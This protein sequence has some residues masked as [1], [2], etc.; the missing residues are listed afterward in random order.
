MEP[1]K[2][3]CNKNVIHLSRNHVPGYFVPVAVP[4]L[5]VPYMFGRRRQV[6]PDPCAVGTA[7]SSGT[8]STEHLLAIIG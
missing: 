6:P 5:K 2:G 8:D 4:Y 7:D 1:K 3:V